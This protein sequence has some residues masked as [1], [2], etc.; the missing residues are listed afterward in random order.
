M[1]SIEPNSENGAHLQTHTHTYKQPDTILENPYR[2][3]EQ[4]Y[5]L[6]LSFV[7][8]CM[9]YSRLGTACTMTLYAAVKHLIVI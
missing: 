9:G 6:Q 3:R 8:V 2:N 4:Q 7:H 5:H 1:D